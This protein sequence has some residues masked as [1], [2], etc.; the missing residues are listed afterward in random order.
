MKKTCLLLLLLLAPLLAAQAQFLR[1]G[2]RAGGGFARA[3]GDYS[4]DMDHLAGLTAG[5]LFNYDF[6]SALEL[7]A[8]LSYEQKG[9]TYN[10]HVLSP[11]EYE[12]GD[13]RL[14]YLDVPV[15]VKVRK[16]GLFAEAGPYLG[17]LVNEDSHTERLSSLGGSGTPPEVLGPREYTMADYERWDYGYVAGIGIIMDNGFFVTLRNTGGLR[18]FSK[19]LNQKNAMWQLS[20]GFLRPSRTKAN[21]MR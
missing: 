9:F 3:T 19:V 15:L 17:Y 6:V 14:H 7:Q 10:E 21:L 2:A 13:I 20:V 4:D 16:N 18:S 1:F 8:E 5:F 11:T 12:S